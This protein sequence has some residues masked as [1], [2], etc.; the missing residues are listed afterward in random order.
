MHHCADAF[1]GLM[2]LTRSHP[3]RTG[4]LGQALKLGAKFIT[5]WVKS[6]PFW[7]A[8]FTEHEPE[9]RATAE[10]LQKGTKVLQVRTVR[11]EG[12]MRSHP[13]SIPHYLLGRPLPSCSP[14]SPHSTSPLPPTPRPASH[15]FSSFLSRPYMNEVGLYCS[16]LFVPQS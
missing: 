4:V 3:H 8:A 16:N 14:P 12:S 13:H 2:L 11:T 9:F 5:V 10:R 7:Q 15:C 1:A 6:L